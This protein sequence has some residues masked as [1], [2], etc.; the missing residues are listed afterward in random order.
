MYLSLI[1]F[2]T[3]RLPV[4]TVDT[5]S[6]D[7]KVDTDNT[8]PLKIYNLPVAAS[9]AIFDEY[10]KHLNACF[11]VIATV[12]CFQWLDAVGWVAERTSGP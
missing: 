11:L 12:H 5:D 4:V 7:I 10:V 2:V 1:L 8:V 6:G 9:F 3:V